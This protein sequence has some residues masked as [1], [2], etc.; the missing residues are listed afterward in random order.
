MKQ[1]VPFVWDKACNNAF[2]SIK[3]YLSSPPVLGA[4][5]PGKP[6]ILYI[7]AQ[8]R[9]VGALM[10]QENE[11]QKEGALYYLSRMLT[12]AEL[13]YSPIEKICLALMFAIQKLRHYMHAYTIHLVAKA[14]PIIYVP[15]KAV[16]GQALADFFADHPIPADW[17]ISDDLPDENVFYID[18]FPTWTIELCSNNVAEYQALIIGLQMAINMEITALEIYGDS[19]LI[20]NQLLT[21]YEVRKD[22]LVPYFRLATQLLQRFEAVTLEHVPRKENQMA[23][24]LAN[25]ALS[26]TLG[27]DEAANVP[28]C[29]RWV[30]PLVTEIVLSNTNVISILPVNVEEWR[31]PLI[32]YLEHGILPDDP[33]HRSEVREEEANQAMEEAHSGICG[34]HQSGPKLHFQ[35]K[36]MGYYWPSMVKDCLEH[37]KRCQA[38]QFHANFIHQPPEPLHPTATSWPFD[39]WGLDVVG[40]ITPKSSAGEAYI[41]AATD[42]FSKWAEAIPLKEV[43]KETVFSNRLVDELCEKYKFKQHRS[44]MYHAPANGL[45]E[46][47]NKTLCNLLKKVIGR[48]KRDWHERIGDALWAYRTTYRTPTQATPYSLVYGVEAVLPLESQIP[49]LRMA[50]QEGLTDEENAKLR[51]QELEALDEKRLEAQQHLE[52]YQARLSKAF[53][54]KV[55]PRPFQMGDLVLS[56]RRPIITTHKTKSKFTSKWDGPYVIQ[57]V[58]TNGAYLIMAEDGLKIGPI[59]G[60]FLKRYYP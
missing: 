32:N 48:T 37:A 14:D 59:N 60:R 42:Y 44:S 16:K 58:Y 9:S 41:L 15:A 31:Q 6:L 52:C 10:A 4:P 43:K 3:K 36:R 17:K 35:L 27:E 22:D 23:D 46:A 18:I 47:F 7:A 25:L 57:E 50:I 8:E 26:M 38:C 51:L 21:E 56:L 55:L 28:V 2:E 11:S 1:D 45:A 5:V 24:A 19:K 40:P 13:N 29:Q 34:A 30:I 49:S 54:K 20:I 39:A 33:K 12:G 53:N